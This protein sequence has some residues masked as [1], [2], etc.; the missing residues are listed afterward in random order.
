MLDGGSV[1][2]LEVAG[3]TVEFATADRVVD[4]PGVTHLRYRF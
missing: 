4:G 3:L 1:P 2:I